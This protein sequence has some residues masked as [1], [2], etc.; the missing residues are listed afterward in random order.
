MIDRNPF[1]N[2]NFIKDI[3]RSFVPSKL[4]KN[5][6]Y[7]YNITDVNFKSKHN[8]IIQI[9]IK[10]ENGDKFEYM[11]MNTNNNIKEIV[12]NNDLKESLEMNFEKMSID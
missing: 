9:V 7:N 8:N 12:K 4:F 11:Y 5:N 3:K 2:K 10:L 6:K 1:Y